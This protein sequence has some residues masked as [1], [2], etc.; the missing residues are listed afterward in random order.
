[1]TLPPGTHVGPYEIKAK[2]GAGGMGEVFRG[3]DAALHRDVAI[4]VLPG[5]LASDPERL[6]RFRREAQVLASLNH[7]NIAHVYGFESA[8]LPD[9]STAHFLAMELAEGEDL[10]E[11]LRRG[12]IPVEEAVVIAK[13]MA[14]GLEDAH[15]HGIIHRD[16]KPANV[17]LTAEGKVKIL[18]FGLAKAL[19]GDP[20]PS[21]AGA[22]LSHS[23]TLSRH[24]TEAGMIMG[25]A[26]Y[27]SPEQ[28][29]GKSVDKRAD[30]WSFG[31]VVFEMLTGARL[32]SGETVSDTLASVL[33]EEVPW[34]RLPADTPRPVVQVLKRCLARDPRE[35]LRDVGDARMGLE[36]AF[37]SGAAPAA[38]SGTVRGSRW[39]AW[40]AWTMAAMGALAGGA[41]VW[42]LK[43]VPPSP[44]LP[45]A[46]ALVPLSGG[47]AIPPSSVVPMAL[48]P[49]GSMMVYAA[50][51]GNEP[52]QL[53]LRPMDS[54]QSQPILG[55][56]GATGPFFSPDGQWVG[57]FAARQLRK[58]PVTG[59]VA[60]TICNTSDRA[61]GANW[62]ADN[63]IIFGAVGVRNLYR[64][65]AEG[66]TPEA[67]TSKGEDAENSFDR[68][69]DAPPGSRVVLF[70]SMA[71]A[72][73]TVNE[74]N[75]VAQRLDTGERKVLIRGATFPHYVST[76]HLIFLAAGSLM[77]VPLNLDSLEVT[78]AP[79]RLLEGVV[80]PSFSGGAGF[81]VARSGTLAY[82]AGSG[83]DLSAR[84]VWVDR[85]GGKEPLPAPPRAYQFPRISP[86]G[87]RIAVAF[88][89]SEVQV[90]VYDVLRSSLTRQ[91][92]AGRTSSTPLW[93]PDGKRLAYVSSLPG[94]LTAFWQMADGGGEREQLTTSN[95]QTSPSSF[96]PD[97]KLLAYVEDSAS[98]GRSIRVLDLTTRKTEPFSE[99]GYEETA[100]KFSP[101]GRWIAYSSTESGRREIY[102]R[103]FPGPGGKWQISNDGGQEPL[104]NPRGGEV[105]YRNG[106]KVMA[107][108]VDLE[109]GFRAEA[110]RVL[111]EGPYRLTDASFPYYDVSPDGKR[112]LMLEPVG[113]ETGVTQIN[114]IFNWFE[115]LKRLAPTP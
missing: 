63:Q 11:R 89:D 93:T 1:M 43:P 91:T 65:S 59:G 68:W 99:T 47:E 20:A 45:V 8:G 67:L 72:T 29:R 55:T 18:D 84:M 60:L 33:K 27:M 25:T 94:P 88:L 73:I 6:A 66:G 115:E 26:A 52:L 38:E 34:D 108:S 32:F 48:S 56:E 9:G 61:Q 4:K 44:A 37:E 17:K 113:P 30:I 111:F 13:Q 23:P 77:A 51:K 97:G 31:V 58:I 95:F 80:A 98:A 76:G 16:L 105:F 22:E 12:P 57:F 49:D 7:P 107:V 2:I 28:A 24:M 81:A 103:P 41:A 112:F 46:R 79:V 64:V 36:G 19:E 82:V 114:V 85:R 39:G 53:Y 15:E 83:Q 14:E 87:Q 62:G 71:S 106:N 104:W 90:W 35:R 69:P 102:L 3:H 86:D 21:S 109:S 110:P 42:I 5:A 74:A 92:F 70:A 78:G 75:I 10:A 40:A 96:S 100:P 101:D 54:A 50:Q